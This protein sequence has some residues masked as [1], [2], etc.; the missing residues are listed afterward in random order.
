MSGRL[1]TTREVAELVS[2]SPETILRRYRAGELRGVRL[3]SNVLRF[4]ESDVEAWLE[5][6]TASSCHLGMEIW[7]KS[8]RPDPE[9]EPLHYTEDGHWRD[10]HDGEWQPDDDDQWRRVSLSSQTD[11]EAWLLGA[12]VVYDE[13]LVSLGLL[14]GP[15]HPEVHIWTKRKFPDAG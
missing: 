13:G 4:R 14:L 8:A 7:P 6:V 9:H 12:S 15:L 1:L 10:T 11:W 5:G 3:G 2:L